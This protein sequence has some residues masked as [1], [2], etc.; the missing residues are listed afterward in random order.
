MADRDAIECP[1]PLPINPIAISDAVFHFKH[2]HSLQ[3]PNIPVRRRNCRL[4]GFPADA[5]K[6]VTIAPHC[7]VPFE[8]GSIQVNR[9]VAIEPVPLVYEGIVNDVHA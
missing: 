3:K 1:Y 2:R 4:V 8:L 9:D 7:R 6:I 5:S